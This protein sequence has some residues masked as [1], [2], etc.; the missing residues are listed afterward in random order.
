VINSLCM[1]IETSYEIEKR[2]L[3][4]FEVLEHIFLFVYVAELA[5]RF[6]A[7]GISCL[8]NPWVAF[9]FVLVFM[10]VVS[11]YIVGPII[12]NL[13]EGSK[14]V[15]DGMA[16]LLVLRMLRLFRLARAV[17]LLVQFK[18]LWMLIR[19]L[20][21]SA[22]TIAYTFGLILL[23]LYICSCMAMELITKK[24]IDTDDEAIATLVNDLFPSIPVAMLT[25]L[26][27]VSMDSI[28]SIYHPLIVKDP[29]LLI[30]FLPFILVVSIS[31]MNLVTAVIVEGAIEQG[32]QDREAQGRYK[33]HRLK[34]MLPGLR[35]LFKALDANGDGT[36]T[37]EE[38]KESPPE[39][40]QKLEE[41]MQADSVDDLFEMV[42]V[43]DSGEVDID[44]FVDGISKVVT[45]NTSVENIR[46]LKQ[47]SFTRKELQEVK[48]CVTKLESMVEEL[49]KQTA[50][51]LEE[52]KARG[53][54]NKQELML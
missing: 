40:K 47:L 16:G 8:K 25:L 5:L 1:G 46:M 19:G 32:N 44:E 43:D 37:L 34:Q 24:W 26:Q 18:T 41:F 3:T 13:G 20:L 31:L 51:V 39:L 10:G 2:D 29:V 6:F 7:Y 14:S 50:G 21:G 27:F 52:I 11:N 15:Q 38:I 54:E 17:R 23:I 35:E 42:D 48:G 4:A 49:G 33:Q 53:T 22:G 45:A 9:D 36:V 12:Q 30:F 28:A